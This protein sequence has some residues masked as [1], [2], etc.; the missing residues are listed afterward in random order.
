MFYISEIYTTAPK[1]F[2]TPLQEEVYKTLKKLKIPFERVDTD[3][4]VSMD[5]CVM[6]NQKLNMEMVK[7]LFLCNR[8]KTIFYLFITTESKKFDTKNFSEKMNV[9]RVSFAPEELFEEILGTKIG[10]ATVFSTIT[11]WDRTIQ[12]VFDKD[13]LAN[14]WYGCSD[15]TNTSY[16]KI[17]T[18][19]VVGKLLPYTK[20]RV[21][22]V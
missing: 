11:D 12:V 4:A 19:D 8:K 21:T 20:H 2:Q 18:E 6:I 14:E 13:V 3:K 9:A 16:M 15:G 7:T 17:R 5:D 22:V 1:E 10:A